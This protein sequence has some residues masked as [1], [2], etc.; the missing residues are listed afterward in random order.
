MAST[1]RILD[2]LDTPQKIK[3]NKNSI[4]LNDF[5][6]DIKFKN[7]NFHYLEVNQFLII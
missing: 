2:L 4:I 5:N 7:I 3:D 1:K 6:H